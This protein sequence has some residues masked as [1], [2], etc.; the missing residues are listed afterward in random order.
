ME[1]P[2]TIRT[3]PNDEKYPNHLK[4]EEITSYLADLK[5]NEFEGD[6]DANDVLITADTIVWFEDRAMEKPADKQE[7]VS[8]L[9]R[10]SG[11]IHEVAT[12]VCI[13]IGPKRKIFSE[14][15]EVHFNNLSE[16]E[17]LYYVENFQPFD[18]AGAYGIQEWIGYIGVSKLKGCYYNVMGL[19]V[20]N[21]YE[22][23][24]NFEL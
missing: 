23:L 11:N 22:E 7:A 17:I 5:A 10:L 18:K 3:K 15:T 8:M 6:L 16:D 1:L 14:I 12:S 9:H 2:F 13:T 20:K 19:P 21:L 4:R 24:K